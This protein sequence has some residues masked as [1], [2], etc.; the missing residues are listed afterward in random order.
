MG[1]IITGIVTSSFRFRSWLIV[2]LKQYSVN[3]WWR[4]SGKHYWLWGLDA[5]KGHEPH[6]IKVMSAVSTVLY[7]RHTTVCQSVDCCWV[8]DRRLIVP[9]LAV[10]IVYSVRVSLSGSAGRRLNSIGRQPAVIISVRV[11]TVSSELS[12]PLYEFITVVAWAPY[13][14]RELWVFFC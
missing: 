8:M 9:R 12:D 5:E 3:W 6:R 7:I 4:E 11:Y 1:Q 14:L 2:T 10:Y 13:G